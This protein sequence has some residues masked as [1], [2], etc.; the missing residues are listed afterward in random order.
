MMNHTQFAA[1]LFL[2]AAPLG[3][4]GAAVG[5]GVASAFCG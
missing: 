2:A 3:E 4:L 5:G 1:L